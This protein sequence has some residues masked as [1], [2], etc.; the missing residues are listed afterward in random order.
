MNFATTGLEVAVVVAVVMMAAAGAGLAVRRVT[1]TSLL[2][3]SVAHVAVS[4]PAHGVGLV[5]LVVG[6]RRTTLPAR[7]SDASPIARNTEVAIVD[8]RG[9]VAVVCALD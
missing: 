2:V 5:A 6:S 3:G 7:S 1:A 4:I 8:M 9:R